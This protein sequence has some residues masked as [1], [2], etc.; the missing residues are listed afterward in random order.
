V[1]PPARVDQR[2]EQAVFARVAQDVRG[3][4]RIGINLREKAVFVLD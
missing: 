4:I 3:R 1:N 2:R